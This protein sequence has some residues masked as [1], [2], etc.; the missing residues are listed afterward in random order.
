MSR[1]PRWSKRP[2]LSMKR[3]RSCQ[4]GARVIID[5]SRLRGN[6]EGCAPV[7]QRHSSA[8]RT[9]SRRA[10]A[11]PL[12]L[13]TCCFDHEDGRSERRNHEGG[14]GTV[15]LSGCRSGDRSG[16]GHP[17][18]L[19]D[20]C[21]LRARSRARDR[22]VR[23]L[24]L[25]SDEGVELE[26]KLL[27]FGECMT[28]TSGEAPAKV[29]VLPL[30][31]DADG[32]AR[33]AFASSAGGCT[34]DPSRSRRPRAARIVATPAGVPPL[35]A[36]PAVW[37]DERVGAELEAAATGT[38]RTGAHGVVPDRVEEPC[39][40]CLRGR[41]VP[42]DRQGATVDRTGRARP[43]SGGAIEAQS[44]AGVRDP[45]RAIDEFR[46]ATPSEP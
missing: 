42:G 33:R 45:E 11:D 9:F 20:R 25:G 35:V 32:R 38:E 27:H 43:A 40:G 29:R 34:R 16:V 7:G 30:L 41:V 15:V 14:S 22:F 28:I 5:L 36:Q 2:P 10:P 24:A 23:R 1:P 13:T 8:N 44:E 17:R 6:E 26:Q 31:G 12:P 21:S 18:Q 19:H 37:C 46:G 3:A 4:T 39:H